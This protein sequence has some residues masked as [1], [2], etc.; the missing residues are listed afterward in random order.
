MLNI[1]TPAYKWA[2]PLVSG[3]KKKMIILHHAAAKKMS[4]DNIHTSHINRGFAGIGYHYYVRKDG[5]VY[6]GRPDD[7]VGAHTTNYNSVGI[8]ICAEGNYEVEEKMPEAQKKA[9]IEL[10]AYIMKLYNIKEIHK[11]KDLDATACPGKNYPFDEIVKGAI[12]FNKPKQQKYIVIANLLN[13]R[14]KPS[15]NSKVI[16]TYKKDE[17]IVAIE[18]YGSWIKTNKGWVS[19]MYLKK[20]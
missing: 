18:E 2:K 11:H 3:N 16:G 1:I 8:G 19:K 15:M 5:T 14:E 6:K 9:L 20:I 10:C 4:V 7:A 13:I 17:I 12:E